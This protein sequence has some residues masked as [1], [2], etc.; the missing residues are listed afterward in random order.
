MKTIK[1]SLWNC[2]QCGRQF[3]RHNQAH[4]CKI[5][6]LELHFE[7]K[8]ASKILYEKLCEKIKK[9]VG[10]YKIESL[11]CCIHLVST[12]TFAA[13][14]LLKS[15]I[16]ID[17]SLSRQLKNKRF[18]K[19]YKLSENRFLYLV[20][21]TEEEEIDNELLI[22]IVEAYEIKKRK[23]ISQLFTLMN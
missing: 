21:I 22:W 6:P 10:P 17:F 4:S 19:T 13:V 9:N 18:V 3:E 14:K 8:D 1:K 5:Y 11:E 12:S 16:Q 20:E 2:P 15:K 7:G 23:M